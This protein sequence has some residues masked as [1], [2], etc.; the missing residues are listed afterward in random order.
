MWRAE[1]KLEQEFNKPGKKMTPSFFFYINEFPPPPFFLQADLQE[2]EEKFRK[3]MVLNAQLDNEKATLMYEVEFL[4][5][6][7]TDL[8]EAHIQLTVSGS[9][10]GGTV[11]G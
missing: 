1:P 11:V 9:R 4:K 3:A 6:K 7:Y 2:L 10:A 8:E 5:D